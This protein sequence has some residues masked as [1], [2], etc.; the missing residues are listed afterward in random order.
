MPAI[1]SYAR[2]DYGILEEVQ[3]L[4]GVETATHTYPEEWPGPQHYL[5]LAFG[6]GYH[7]D[8]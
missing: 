8:R 6:P 2:T 3:R 5:P 4:K 7:S 1:L